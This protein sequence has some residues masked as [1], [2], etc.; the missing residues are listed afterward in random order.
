[1]PDKLEDL[2]TEAYQAQALGNIP[3]TEQLC[4]QILFED[5]GNPE[6][7]AMLGI[8]AARSGNPILA[9]SLL[10][11]AMAKWPVTDPLM[12]L[13][14]QHQ[15]TG[16]LSRALELNAKAVELSPANP[17]ALNALG[18]IQS[19]MALYLEA[20]ESFTEA[21]KLRPDVGSIQ[22]NLGESL[23]SQDR[24][25]EALGCFQR[26]VQLDPK[27]ALSYLSL[28]KAYGRLLRWEKAAA[29]ARISLDMD[30]RNAI[31][32]RLLADAL[33]R[34]GKPTE[35][36][37]SMKKVVELEPNDA[38]FINLLGKSYQ[39][40]GQ[41]DAADSSF[42]KSIEINPQQGFAY[43]ALVHNNRIS[44]A[45]RPLV[46]QMEALLGANSLPPDQAEF[47][48]Y[49]LGKA[50]ENLGEYEKAMAHYDEA[51]RLAFQAK[52]EGKKFDKEAYAASIDQTISI[53][54]KE[55][56]ANLPDY[57][58]ENLKPILIVGMMRSGT[59]LVEQV[60][61]SH[62][63][64]APGGELN[65]WASIPTHGVSYDLE[66]MQPDEYKAF[67]E[68]YLEI[69]NKFGPGADQVT[70][71]M[72]QNFL[73]IGFILHIFPNARIIHTRRNG[74]DIC[75]SNYTTANNVAVPY[76]HSKENIAFVYEQHL[77]LAEHWR[78]VLPADRYLEVD[79]EDL[80]SDGEPTIRRMVEFCGLEWDD[81]CLRPEQSENFVITPSA[82]QV[83]QPLYTDSIGRWRHYEPWLGPFAKFVSQ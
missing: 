63:A 68:G 59:T 11:E 10:E 35:S 27:S 69:L 19:K 67:A 28:S 20:S 2:L 41:I 79:Y 45:D 56:M 24:L 36:L 17:F 50:Y 57:G 39:G 38:N 40:V 29:A 22:T 47:L 12:L 53:F 15:K 30:P 82:W 73:W 8:I 42:R 5:P 14:S 33:S 43:F 23:L 34:L 77:K 71:K 83:R 25:Q 48:E 16:N 72:P 44:E 37:E 32:H 66:K 31:A 76:A 80:V 65:Y 60:L 18:I 52:F 1:M 81:R 49:G 55:R 4:T 7:K 26:A 74:A 64:V 46:N 51:N 78:K 58:S 21:G 75:I 61:A 3:K 70:D 62:P 9:I 6:A 13:A 54:T